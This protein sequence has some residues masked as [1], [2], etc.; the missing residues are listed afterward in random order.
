[1]HRG[2]QD[3]VEHIYKIEEAMIK[4]RTGSIFESSAD[5]YVNPV[6]CEGVAGKGLALQFRKEF[7]DNFEFYRRECR[8][9]KVRP[10]VLA[11]Y[12][13]N[14]PIPPRWIINFPTKDLWRNPSRI[15][16]IQDGMASLALWCVHTSVKSV[17]IPALGCGLGNLDWKVVRPLIIKSLGAIRNLEVYT[18]DPL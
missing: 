14:S 7:P 3:S 5:A 1:M 18:F 17:A 10:G 11:V 15:E 9:G 8:V 13:R 6:N 16:F 4:K 2:K 12:Q